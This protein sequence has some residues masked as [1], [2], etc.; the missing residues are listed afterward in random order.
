MEMTARSRYFS[1]SQQS[2]LLN[3]LSSKKISVKLKRIILDSDDEEKEAA[4]KGPDTQNGK[5][6]PKIEIVEKD[7]DVFVNFTIPLSIHS[8]G[9]SVFYRYITSKDA[10]ML[11]YARREQTA[12][13]DQ[14]VTPP[15][16][17]EDVLEEVQLFN[18]AHE[19]ACNVYTEKFV[20]SHNG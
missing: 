9:L 1:S 6:E 14:P 11:I 10:Y 7:S 15:E 20:R 4:S 5:E 18:A 8:L 16:P 19:E 2:S 12:P 3:A 13:T 17:P